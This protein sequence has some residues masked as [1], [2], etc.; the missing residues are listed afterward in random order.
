MKAFLYD[1]DMI[2][3]QEVALYK[4]STEHIARNNKIEEL[5]RHSNARILAIEPEYL[6]I[7]KT[8][9]QEETQEFLEQ[10][11]PFEVHEFIRSG[12]VIVTK[13]MKSLFSHLKEL[14]DEGAYRKEF[15]N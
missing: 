1:D 15:V 9:N 12:R 13:P 6:V 2:L 8:G 3:A 7:E 14:E 10:L 5:I 4:I 11:A